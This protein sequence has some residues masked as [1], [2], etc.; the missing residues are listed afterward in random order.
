MLQRII[1]CVL[2]GVLTAEFSWMFEEHWSTPWH[3]V[4]DFLFAPLPGIHLWVLDGL[5][6]VFL[7]IGRSQKGAMTGRAKPMHTAIWV[8]LGTIFTFAIWG[9]I[10]GAKVLDMRIQ[11]HAIV[12]MMLASFMYMATFRT[13]EHFRMLGATIVYAALFRVTM[14]FLFYILVMRNL[15]VYIAVI[16]D[17]GDSIL[18]VLAI[19]I[20]IANAIHTKEKSTTWKAVLVTMAMLWAIQ[21]NNRR[22]AWVGLIGSLLIIY[23]LLPTGPVRRKI[24]RGL[25][26]AA[27][28]LALYVAVGWT[29]P[30][31]FF[32]PIASIQS[33]ND[34]KDPSTE[35]RNLENIGLIV[36]LQKNPLIAEG[37]GH[38]YVEVSTTYSAGLVFPQYKMVPHNSVLGIAAFT[39]MVG[40]CG[41]WLMFPVAVYLAARSYAFSRSGLEKSIAMVT[42]CEVLVHINQMWGDIGIN[43]SQGVVLM[44]AAFAAAA[45][46]PLWSGAWPGGK[47]AKARAKSA[48]PSPAPSPSPRAA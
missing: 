34:A 30:T 29:S 3:Y 35:S 12:M 39:G 26:T 23:F 31:G 19:V 37:F 38:E 22:L 40:F 43:A 21:M 9:A 48:A 13:P 6:V 32:K 28:I 7:L 18:F 14:M 1:C 46:A 15:T 17:H 25:M 20:M 24:H 11:L 27:P 16:T 10:N 33:M 45:R 41:I 44:S 8:S 4:A 2:F 36:T 42:I 5:F 47:K